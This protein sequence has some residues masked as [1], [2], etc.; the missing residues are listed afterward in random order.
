MSTLQV[1]ISGTVVQIREATFQVKKRVDDKNTCTFSVVDPSDTAAYTK[2]HPVTADDSV[3]GNRFVGFINKPTCT[4]L[5]P[6][7]TNL[8]SIDCV[9]QF[10]VAA[11]KA[12]TTTKAKPK[13]GGKHVKQHS[14]AIVANQIQQYLEPDGIS[15]NFGLN[16]SELQADWQAATQ[17]GVLA[18]TNTTTAKFDAGDLELAPNGTPYTF[19]GPFTLA[20]IPGPT[21]NALYLTSYPNASYSSAIAKN[22]I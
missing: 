8:W 21:Q 22:K 10:Y 11:K 6:Q 16:W 7:A 13:R 3:L 18:A 1:K 20:N 2:A 12:T 15:G 17:I 5:Y 4:N 14:G 19:K 9:S